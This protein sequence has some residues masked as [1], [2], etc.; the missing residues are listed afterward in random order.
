MDLGLRCASQ[1]ALKHT[2]V[3]MIK[4]N[5]GGTLFGGRLQIL[6]RASFTKMDIM[7]NLLEPAMLGVPSASESE[8]PTLPYFM[9]VNNISR[10]YRSNSFD[11]G[12]GSLNHSE[13]SI[14]FKFLAYF[15]HQNIIGFI[16]SG[17][18]ATPEAPADG[19]D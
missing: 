4:P 2:T 6:T 11:F 19:I 9:R 18:I 5:F 3:T 15:G 13:T 7:N 10:R 14:V 8:C 17:Q 12:I 16:N 1:M